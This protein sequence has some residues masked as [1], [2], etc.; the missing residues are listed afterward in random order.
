MAFHAP[1]SCTPA[2]GLELSLAH[3]QQCLEEVVDDGCWWSGGGR[4]QDFTTLHHDHLRRLGRPENTTEDAMD[5]IQTIG[6]VGTVGSA[7]P[8]DHTQSSHRGIRNPQKHNH[9]GL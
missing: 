1:G 4:H 2:L 9:N 6:A 8:L 3:T 7:A 5:A